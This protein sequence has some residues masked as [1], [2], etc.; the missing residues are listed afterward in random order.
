MH[1]KDIG[2]MQSS[3]LTLDNDHGLDTEGHDGL[4]ADPF[5][6]VA[7]GFDEE[8]EDD[9]DEPTQGECEEDDYDEDAFSG[10]QERGSWWRGMLSREGPERDES[11]D[12]NGKDD[13]VGDIDDDEEFGD[14]TMAESDTSAG[15]GSARVDLQPLFVGS[16][17]EAGRGLGGLWPFG[18]RT[19]KDRNRSQVQGQESS[20]EESGPL[21][22]DK[23]NLD[24]RA[25]A[26]LDRDESDET[27]PQRA[28]QVS[29]AKRRTSIEDAV[30]EE[31]EATY[32]A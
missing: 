16:S 12:G 28:V 9:E 10:V 24:S 19:D 13:D 6:D 8:R 32:R 30:E 7:D 21:V 22:S 17:K 5:A 20:R 2:A 25:D 26:E 23:A 31:E 3:A 15:Q 14:F 4:S 27:G 1:Q 11:D 29:Q 18:S